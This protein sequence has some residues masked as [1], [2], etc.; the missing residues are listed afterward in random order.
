MEHLIDIETGLKY[1]I[2]QEYVGQYTRVSFYDGAT[3]SNIWL[4]IESS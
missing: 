4:Y 1:E 2:E 3:F